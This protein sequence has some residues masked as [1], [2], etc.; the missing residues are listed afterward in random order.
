MNHLRCRAKI[1]L[2]I[3][4]ERK[5]RVIDLY[6]NQEKTTRE[7][8]KIERMSIRDI[9][10]ILK[11]EDLK[12]QR[13]KDQQ[14]QEEV[15]SKA[16]E[17]FSEGKKPIEVAITLNLREPE[18][19]KLYREYWMLKRL[20]ILN[21]IYKETNGKL[22]PFL[23][24][25][26]QL[27]KK[28]RMTIE[29]LVNAVDI[30]IHKLPYMEDLY[31][32]VT[33]EVDELQRTREGLINHIEALKYKLSILDKAALSSE[34]ERKKIEQQLQV[35]T[36]QKDRLEKWSARLSNNDDDLK[37]LVKENV[38]AV[39]SENKQVISLSFTALIQTLKYDPEIIKLIY[40]ILLTANTEY[41]DNSNNITKYLEAN[42]DALLD[43]IEKQ[44]EK[45]AE[46]LTKNTI[47]IAASASSSSSSSDP[48]LS[49]PSSTLGSYNQN[50]MYR[51]EET[52]P[53]H[54][55]KGDIAD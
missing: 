10:P 44:Y 12:R 35:L 20:Y 30:A 45:L 51:I 46:A 3:S 49:L 17:L 52:E 21:C 47:D 34:E 1:T 4:E 54:N 16:Y 48:K 25:Y 13:Y 26:K 7:I 39:L 11:E 40:N 15:S 24:I 27:V 55:S 50:D 36:A 18:A 6:Y 41:K 53:Y 19:T 43:L 8:A 29:Q 22:G 33:R 2:T 14:Q 31:K 37:Q 28:R 32:Q 38:K 5:K 9:S 23:K 42:K